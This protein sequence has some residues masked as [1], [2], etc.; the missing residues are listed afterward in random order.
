MK[1]DEIENEIMRPLSDEDIKRLGI[2]AILKS[3]F[4]GS[5]P[6]VILY[7]NTPRNGHWSLL[8]RTIDKNGNKVIEFF[9]SYGYLPDEVIKVMGIPDDNQIV[10][11]LLKNEGKKV[12]S[13]LKPEKNIRRMKKVS[14]K[15]GLNFDEIVTILTS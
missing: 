11:Y 1:I 5:L 4:N 9:D 12:L 3:E 13:I 6:R 8:H 10:K 15:S 7:E 2:K 14:K